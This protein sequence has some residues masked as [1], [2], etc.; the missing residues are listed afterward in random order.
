MTLPLARA[1]LT[2]NLTLRQQMI[3][4]LVPLLVLLAILGWAGARLLAQLGGR[5]DEI[6]KENYDSVIYMKDLNE[7]LE[8]IDSSFTFTLN[9][10]EDLGWPQY[11]ANRRNY[12]VNLRKEQHNITLPG[13]KELVEELTALSQTYKEKGDVFYRN[14]VL[15]LVVGPGGVI[16]QRHDA[17]FGKRGLLTI[18]HKLKKVSGAIHKLNEQNMYDV[19]AEARHTARAAR[20]WFTVG[21]GGIGLL[22]LILVVTTIRTVLRRIR[23]VT[24]SALAIGTGN[25][26]QVV[27]VV[28]RDELGQL[29]S[30]FNTMARQL[31]D[32]RQSDRARLLRAQQ[33]SQAT[34]DSFPDPVVVIDQ[35]GYV[36][37][38]NP[39]ALRLL[40][41][42]S[43]GKHPAHGIP[44]HPPEG[45]R[46]PLAEV[47]HNQRAYL[48]ERFEQAIVLRD[49]GKERSFLPRL[50]P[51]RDPYGSTLGAAVLLA[52]VTRL[53]LLDEVKSNLVATVSHELK[54]PLTSIRLAL[55][56]LVEETIG[57][58][59]PKQLEL[60]LDARE[61]TERLL[62]TINNLLDLARLEEGPRRL[63]LRRESPVDLLRSAAGAIRP[64]AEGKGVEVAILGSEDLPL[65]AADAKQIG[66]ALQ[67]LLDNALTYTSTGGQITLTAE[68]SGDKV[69]L[70]VA[71]NGSGIP[72][73]FL[74]HVFE[75]FF[76][77]PGKSPQGG[78]GL[79]LAIVREIVTAHGGTVKCESRPGEGTTIRLTLF[80][81]HGG[82]SA[83]RGARSAERGE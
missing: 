22:A 16:A 47:L 55:H 34:I 81:D 39:A 70:S 67:N 48:P 36:E 69:T 2:M 53:R 14:P 30:A 33:T 18:F 27:P 31:R 32:F 15:W 9:G 35:E 83:E 56:L 12:Q 37:L 52:D 75:R 6:L 29:A 63:D 46:G 80:V 74:P 64:R 43:D 19:S 26:D 62:A 42:K 40:G 78:T 49:G 73:E 24:E 25:L 76:R 59:L 20:I 77:V 72:A 61:N 54:T 23:S 1:E 41:V 82:Q 11:Q 13:E 3:L 8:R 65:V 58:L 4:T 71:D 44:W 66:H 28:F 68:A 57:P 38:A 50:L 5:I 17:Y 51:I 10:R 79:G 45:I 7:A 60:L 21:L